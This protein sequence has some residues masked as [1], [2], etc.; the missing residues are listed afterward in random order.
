[1]GNKVNFERILTVT[2]NTKEEKDANELHNI[3]VLYD[4]FFMK[5]QLTME[6]MTGISLLKDNLVLIFEYGEVIEK[7]KK[8]NGGETFM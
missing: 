1:M 4:S 7:I 2:G 8:L 3:K 6:R 5:L